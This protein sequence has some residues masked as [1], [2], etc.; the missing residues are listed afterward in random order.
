MSDTPS[1][2]CILN[3]C[4]SSR[5]SDVERLTVVGGKGLDRVLGRLAKSLAEVSLHS[6]SPMLNISTMENKGA[7]LAELR[8]SGEIRSLFDPPKSAVEPE[9]TQVHGFPDGSVVDLRFVSRLPTSDPGIVSAYPLV[10]ENTT[11]YVRLWSHAEADPNRLTVIGIHGWTMGDQR[12]NSLAFLPGILYRLG[13]DVALVE[14]P[15]HGRRMSANSENEVPL[16]PSVDP[17]LTCIAMAH[18]LQD[19]RTLR[20]YLETKGARRIATV[21]MSLGAYVA[22][23]WASRDLLDRALFLVPLISMGGM[24]WEL[25]RREG[26]TELS[27]EFVMN[28]YAD[29]YPLTHKPRTPQSCMM[30]IVGQDDHLVPK[31]QITE[32]QTRWPEV[33]IQWAQGGHSA[34]ARR[35]DTFLEII[36]FLT[37]TEPNAGNF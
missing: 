10:K 26:H 19:L 16:F 11:S 12:V 25:L 17:L 20:L 3:G 18:A 15:F 6:F 5:L 22:A 14:L 29:H 9:V 7:T 31:S 28:L 34:V 23:V 8:L 21:G 37:Q 30:G 35:Q 13:F 24:A 1:D 4:S 27:K 33:N 32:L 2:F 36:K